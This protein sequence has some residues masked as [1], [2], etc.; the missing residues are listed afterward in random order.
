MPEEGAYA[1]GVALRRRH[2]GCRIRET[3]RPR[4]GETEETEK[5]GDRDRDRDRNRR[6]LGGDSRRTEVTCVA[7]EDKL[8]MA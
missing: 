7:C 4:D 6:G 3:E 5:P 1:D 8:E 2:G